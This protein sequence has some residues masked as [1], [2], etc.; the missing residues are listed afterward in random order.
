MKKIKMAYP[1][2]LEVKIP[3]SQAATA[4]VAAMS[5]SVYLSRMVKLLGI[6]SLAL[7]LAGI[8]LSAWIFI[9]A[10]LVTL[11]TGGVFYWD[12]A[13]PWRR[14]FW[15]L[16]EMFEASAYPDAV[17]EMIKRTPF[18]PDNAWLSLL[19]TLY[20]G[21]GEAEDFLF[22]RDRWK[23]NFNPDSFAQIVPQFTSCFAEPTADPI[24]PHFREF[25]QDEDLNKQFMTTAGFL[26][27]QHLPAHQCEAFWI[28]AVRGRLL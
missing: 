11:W 14:L 10:A 20:P 28:N 13:A 17:R 26:M 23:L 27:Q 19:R 25:V 1:E 12:N 18:D 22:C 3:Q 15:K 16:T 8:F 24:F 4:W 2:H 5:N 9:P 6:V 7:W 21:E